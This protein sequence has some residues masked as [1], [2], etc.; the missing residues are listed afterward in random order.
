M[1]KRL[2]R[3]GFQL[4]GRVAPNRA[5][6]WLERRVSKPTQMKQL[7][8]DQPRTPGSS[9][10][11]PFDDTE[12]VLTEWGEGP[13]VL[14]VHGWGSETRSFY[15]LVDPLVA[16][17]LRVVAV[18]LPAH[19]GSG[20]RRTNMLRC[21]DALL[22]VGAALGPLHT[23]I[24]HSFGGPTAAL[25]A[26]KGLAL[27]RLVM[28][29]PMLSVEKSLLMTARANG[30]PDAVFGRMATGFAERLRFDW[31][32]LATDYLVSRL[33]VPL[34]VVH[35][36][37]DRVTPWSQGAAVARAAP[38]GRLLTTAGLGHRAVLADRR[39]VEQIVDFVA[40]SHEAPRVG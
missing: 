24:A 40:P 31:A 7:P 3:G 37:G 25:A 20:G 29:A 36:E 30:L 8:L 33:E 26:H 14:L 39:I 35:D 34:L 13:T 12:L 32:E 28:V 17:G 21:A 38:R 11:F 4:F 27:E 15:Q 2:V 10:R 1:I 19:G 6:A 23:V 5:A 22:R 18:D 16:T 9:T